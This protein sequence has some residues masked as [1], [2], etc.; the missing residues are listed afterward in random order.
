MSTNPIENRRLLFQLRD[1]DYVEGSPFAIHNPCGFIPQQSSGGMA[2]QIYLGAARLIRQVAVDLGKTPPR[3]SPLSKLIGNDCLP[4][5]SRKAAHTGKG[6]VSHLVTDELR[7][8]LLQPGARL[9]SLKDHL[10][11]ALTNCDRLGLDL[12]TEE[13]KCAA[14]TL[15]RAL[16]HAVVNHA[17]GLRPDQK[18]PRVQHRAESFDLVEGLSMKSRKK[19]QTSQPRGQ[20]VVAERRTAHQADADAER[21]IW[22]CQTDF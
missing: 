3:R 10:F 12:A 2:L 22:A 6:R 18:S 16:E 9:G 4:V 11:E 21:S 5:R 7:T 17:E 13:K 1:E 14:V 8:A 20:Q 19:D 15:R